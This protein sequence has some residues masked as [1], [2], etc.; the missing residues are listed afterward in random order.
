MQYFGIMLL[1]RSE[2][3]Q[4]Q[5]LWLASNSL[6][7]VEFTDNSQQKILT[8]FS[9]VEGCVIFGIYQPKQ[10]EMFRTSRNLSR[11]FLNYHHFLLTVSKNLRNTKK[12]A[13]VW[14]PH[15]LIRYTPGSQKSPN[16]NIPCVSQREIQIL[17]IYILKNA[18]VLT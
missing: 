7:T 10:T 3:L 8:K 11:V 15:F 2:I 12:N 6:Q 9:L 14:D 13:W 16:E 18:L 4:C 1:T 17:L 5:K